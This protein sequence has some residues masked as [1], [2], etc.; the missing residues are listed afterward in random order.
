MLLQQCNEAKFKTF[1][2]KPLKKSMD[3]RMEMKNLYS[4]K[5][6]SCNLIGPYQF[7]GNKAKKF[8]FI[9]QTISYQ[10]VHMGWAQD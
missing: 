10:E 2:E 7:L 1:A 6:S 8:D 9:H 4:N 5:G 3:T